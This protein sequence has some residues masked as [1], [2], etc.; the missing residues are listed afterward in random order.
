MCPLFVTISF[1]MVAAIALLI[2]FAL[3][4]SFIF[5]HQIFSVFGGCALLPPTVPGANAPTQFILVPLLV[6]IFLGTLDI[7]IPSEPLYFLLLLDNFAEA[8]FP[9]SGLAE[10]GCLLWL[11]IVKTARCIMS[12]L[13]SSSNCSG[14]F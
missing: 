13:Y 1:I 5:F 9:A 10:Y 11:W 8:L 2:A 12:G 7:P 6:S 4:F 3:S 14:S